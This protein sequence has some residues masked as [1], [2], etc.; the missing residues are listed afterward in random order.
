M[1]AHPLT[2]W[3][4]SNYRAIRTLIGSPGRWTQHAGARFANG[5]K[6]DPA[7][8]MACRWCLLGAARYVCHDD[9]RTEVMQ[10]VIQT[11]VHNY[12]NGAVRHGSVF[13]DRATHDDL[14]A[15]LEWAIRE[16]S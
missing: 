1:I 11:D 14:L 4:A 16:H 9:E 5:R 15:F 8:P 10:A 6:A 7:D 2:T 12:T 3:T 13:N